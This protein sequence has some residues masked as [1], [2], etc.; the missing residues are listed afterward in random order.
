MNYAINPPEEILETT[1]TIPNSKSIGARALILNY[2]AGTTATDDTCDDTATLSRILCQG[3]PKDGATVDVGPAGT[4]MRFLSALCAATEGVSCT[5]TGSERMLKRPIGPLVEVLRKLGANIE[6]TGE[7]GFPPL[8]IEG[9]KLSGGT[10]DIDA[11][12]SS[13]YISALMMIAPLLDAPLTIKLLGYVQSMPYINMTASMLSRCGAEVEVDREKID[14]AAPNGLKAVEHAEPDWS[15]AAFWYEIAAVTAGWVTITGLP[16][17]SLQGDRHTAA[18]FEQLGVLTEFTDEGAELSATPEIFS[19]F[20][21][22]LSDMPDAVPAIVVTCC[23]T[24]IPFRISGIEALHHKECDRIE[25]LQAEMAKLG[26][27][28]ATEAYGT[29]LTWDGTRRAISELPVF[30]TYNDH[31]MAM[32]LAPVALYLPGIVVKDAQV[33]SKSYPDYWQQLQNAGFTLTEV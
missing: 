5:L 14:V 28:L 30:D 4:A 24:G 8:K 1:V 26:C 12:E 9:K 13:Q 6:Y 31:R 11:S 20:N 29:T 2:L 32:A 10:V 7:E 16:D 21:A 33:V 27:V 3:L 19:F 25:A 17:N 23:L 22:D 15:A 18:L